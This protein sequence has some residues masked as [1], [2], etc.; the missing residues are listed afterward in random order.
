MTRISTH[1]LDTTRGKPAEHVPLRLERRQVNG[2]WQLLASADTDDDGRCSQLLPANEPL[3]PGEYRLS[4]DTTNY[5]ST[6]G[7]VTLYPVVEVTFRVQS[8]EEHFHIPLLL[9]PNGFT[10]YRGT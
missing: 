9:S 10:T 6:R 2:Q 4:F 1:V 5:F 7:V 8:G 3:L